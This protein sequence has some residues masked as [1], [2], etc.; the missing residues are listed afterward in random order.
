MNP[1]T[2]TIAEMRA[3]LLEKASVD[4]TFRARLLSD[5]KA[6]IE[7]ETG[8]AVPAGFTVHVHEEGV[9]TAHLV[10]PPAGT[11]G[12]AQLEQVAG[13]RGPTSGEEIYRRNQN[14]RAQ[15]AERNRPIWG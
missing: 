5:P 4:E 13:G 14:L 2:M 10:L 6:A 7:Q 8:V 12:N 1:T 3:Q 9:D 11:L 15:E